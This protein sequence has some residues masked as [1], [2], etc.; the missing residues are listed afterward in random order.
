VANLALARKLAA[1]FYRLMVHGLEYVEHGLAK[2]TAQV[3][4]TEKRLLQKLARKHGMVLLP[5]NP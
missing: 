4:E 3:Q 5:K 2:Y 1:L